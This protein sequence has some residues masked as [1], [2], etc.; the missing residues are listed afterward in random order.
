MRLLKMSIVLSAL[1]FSVNSQAADFNLV[2]LTPQEDGDTDSFGFTGAIGDNYE[3]EVLA[4]FAFTSSVTG[5]SVLSNFLTSLSS[6]WGTTTFLFAED[7]KVNLGGNNYKSF[8]TEE[9][10]GAGKYT[11]SIAATAINSGTYTGAFTVGRV[12]EVTPVP[13]PETYA[14][15]LAG[16]GL[17]GFASRR[18]NS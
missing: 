5:I 6:G 17:L 8:I 3:F 1:F 14:M 13:E 15:F 11:F 7:G 2:T 10:L 9:I 12:A 4:P 18:R 16:L